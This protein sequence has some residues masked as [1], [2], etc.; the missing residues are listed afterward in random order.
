MDTEK[1]RENIRLDTFERKVQRRIYSPHL[2]SRTG[3]SKAGEELLNVMF[4]NHAS[5]GLRQKED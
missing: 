5:R 3:E 1:D 2:D 4:Q